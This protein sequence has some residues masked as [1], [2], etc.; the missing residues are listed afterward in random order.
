MTASFF[1]MRRGVHTGMRAALFSLSSFSAGA[2]AATPVTQAAHCSSNYAE[3][4]ACR[5]TDVVA[6]DET[7]TMEFTFGNTRVRFVGK[8][9]TGW[10]SGKLDDRPA[11]GY[12]L[13]RGHVI[14]STVDLK[15]TFE[16]WTEG[17]Q[18]GR[19]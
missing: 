5:M 7:H 3:A 12:E 1:G 10:W 4:V 18:H 8:S 16:W 13:N 11:M 17:N 19:Y 9:Q 6:D 2:P 15:T 14:F